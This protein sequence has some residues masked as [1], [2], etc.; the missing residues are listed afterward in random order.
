MRQLELTMFIS[1]NRA[2]FHL[3]WRENQVNKSQDIMKMIVEGP[4]SIR[5]GGKYQFL[6]LQN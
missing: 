2:S 3:W 6:V 5:A 1:N 4:S